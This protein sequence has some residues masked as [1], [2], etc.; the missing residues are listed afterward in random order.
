MS[1]RVLGWALR[2]TVATGSNLRGQ[3]SG[4]GWL[5]ATPRL[6]VGQTVCLT[7]AETGAS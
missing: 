3:A 4:A 5:Y 6:S 7:A 1:D 2:P